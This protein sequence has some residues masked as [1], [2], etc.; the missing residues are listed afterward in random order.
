[1]LA[2][3]SKVGLVCLSGPPDL[4]KT[5]AGMAILRNWGLLGQPGPILQSLLAQPAASRN[6]LAA[7]DQERIA[8]WEWACREMDAIWLVRGGYGLTRILD[9][10]D[11]RYRREIPVVGFSDATA[12]L[13]AL[14]QQGWN[15][16]IHAPNVQTL[17]TLDD[18]SLKCLHSLLLKGS[19]QPLP[20]VQIAGPRLS[21]PLQGKLMGGNL[22]LLASLSGTK[23]QV[24]AKDHILAL[25]DINEPAYRLDRML[26]QLLASGS[27]QGVRAIVTG[28][29]YNCQGAEEVV[30]ERLGPLGVP[31]LARLPFGH[32][33]PHLPLWLNQTVSLSSHQMAWLSNSTISGSGA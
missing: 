2:A 31:I 29:F 6:Y 5:G 12:W 32:T 30:C 4:S 7:S 15:Q 26:T 16:L 21:S 23:W 9:Q 11:L 33:L 17:P 1:M 28:H 3:Q 10:L 24:S 18:G 14:R 22:C 25:E 20:G 8:D 27:L 13:E 19:C